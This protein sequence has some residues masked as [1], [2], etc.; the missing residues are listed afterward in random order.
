[1]QTPETSQQDLPSL[2][3]KPR[4]AVTR[5]FGDDRSSIAQLLLANAIS[6]LSCVTSLPK[7][8]E[9]DAP[10]DRSLQLFNLVM[11]AA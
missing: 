6:F 9:F 8:T 7:S 4:P 2:A 1:M 3:Q 5:R 11:G 10:V